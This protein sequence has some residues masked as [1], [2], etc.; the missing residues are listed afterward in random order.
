MRWWTVLIEL[1]KKI[2]KPKPEPTPVPEEPIPLDSVKWLH[3]DVSK[4]DRTSELK[5]VKFSGDK[6]ILDHTKASE[7]PGKLLGTVEL[8]GNPWIFVNKDG[9]WYAATWE[10]LRYGQTIKGKSSVSGDHIKQAPL[11][12]F[13][14]VIGDTYG[15]MVSGLARTGERNVK[16]RSNVLMVEWK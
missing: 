1:V 13:K 10:W 3:T 11:Y 16:E 14:P 7:W 5:S 9:K 15:F 6:I 8:A 4:W 12:D 2:F